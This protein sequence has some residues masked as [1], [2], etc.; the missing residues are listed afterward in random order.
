MQFTDSHCHLDDAKF[1]EALP[2]LLDECAQ[3]SIERIIIPSVAPDNFNQVLTLSK[4]NSA[5]PIKLFAALGIHPWFLD[6]LSQS[7]LEQ[8][9]QLVRQEKSNIIAVG[10]IGIDGAIS[11]RAANPEVNLQKQQHFFDYQLALAKQENLPVIIH[12]R[13][14]HQYIVPQLKR[15]KLSKTGVIHGFSGSYQQAKD[16]IDLGFKLGIGSTITYSRA[17]KTINAIKRLPLDSLVLETDAPSMPLSIEVLDQPQAHNSPLNLVK[18][19]H[20]LTQ[21]RDES[22]E[23]IAE[24][25]ELNINQV[26]FAE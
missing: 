14:S 21:I 10:E 11:K 12:H 25:I 6:N 18:I 17:K 19:F 3:A 23:Q 2:H 15:H 4:H 1:I 9:T 13:Q 20:C 22:Q 16:Y 24:Q 8:L 26:F 5:K 7:D